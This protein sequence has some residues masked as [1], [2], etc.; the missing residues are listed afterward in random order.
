MLSD[1]GLYKFGKSPL[2][3]VVGQLRFPVLP[4]FAEPSFI[5][6]FQR[7]IKEEY[8]KPNRLQ[9]LGFE[10]SP[11]AGVKPTAGQTLWRF[12]ARDGNWSIVLTETA[13]SLEAR[14]YTAFDEFLSRF[15][16][17]I[18]VA[19]DKLEITD[20]LR[21]GLRY[22]NEIRHPQGQDFA[23]WAKL[24]SPELLGF[25]AHG[26]IPGEVEHMVQETRWRLRDGVLAMRHG[27]L[28]GTVVEP[29]PKEAPESGIF[30][31]VDLDY[32][33]T[34]QCEL[35]LASTVEQITGYNQ[36]MYKLFRWT[37]SDELFQYLEP[38]PCPKK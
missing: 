30:Y 20:R 3:L 1:L 18:E 35:D 38:T 15:R 32:Y 36:L 34:T 26:L 14:R 6:R 11:N 23:G 33:D 2:K 4:E 10:W 21:L 9:Q 17:V 19:S 25:T 24:M 28:T 16:F 27:M 29:R 12:E 8:P 7:S 37:L 13:V 5:T 31:L 22:V